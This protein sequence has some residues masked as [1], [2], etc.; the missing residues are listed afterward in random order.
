MTWEETVDKKRKALLALIP[1]QWRIRSDQLPAES[2]RSVI[3]FVE[4]SNLLTAEELTITKL[5]VQQLAGK[6]ASGEYTAAQVCQVYCH[7]AAIAH[8]LVNCLFEICFDAA[9]EQ[10][11]KLDEYF[12]K[13]GKTVGLLHGVPVSLKDQFRVKGLESSI[14][15]VSGLGT[16]DEDE[17]IVTECLRKAGAIIY[18]KTSVPQSLMIGETVNNI[19]GRTLNPYNRLLSCGGSSG[20]E[21][22]L[23]GFH[24]SPL[25]IGTDV[26]GSIRIP[27]AFNNL[28]CLKPSNERL[29]MGKLKKTVDGNESIPSICGPMAHS[30]GDLAYFM[31]AFLQQEPWKYDPKLI[32]IPWR[33]TRYLEGKTGKKVFGVMAVGGIFGFDGIVMPH[34]PILRGIQQVIIS[35]QKA[36]H[37]V[38]EWQPYKHKYATELTTAILFADGGAAIRRSIESSGEPAIPDIKQLLELKR[39]PIDLETLWKLQSEKY[40]YQKEY[41]NFWQ[42]QSHIDGWILPVAPHTAVKHGDYKYYAYT[43]IINL[44]DWPAM[45]IPVTFADKEIDVKDMQYKSIND[46]DAKVYEG[47]DADIYDG[48]PVGIQLVGR[49]LQEEYLVGLAE[50][51]GQALLG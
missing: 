27:S 35:L 45:T 15:Y 46:L 36:G 23:V 13:H 22:A 2:Q 31:Q 47:Y 30:V 26:G 17:S 16:V 32:D 51:I 43:S 24:G 19:I 48:A 29:P 25:G 6:I 7:R 21:G 38:V 12:Q 11:N 3:S 18:V 37:T 1:D 49:R 10:A 20:G 40:T 42:Q 44:L 8:Q 33:E 9:L 50:Q 34:P 28:W 14:G 39:P 4:E 5:N 41:L